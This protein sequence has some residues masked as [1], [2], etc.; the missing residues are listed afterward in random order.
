MYRA[1]I[2]SLYLD[3]DKPTQMKT[4]ID[5]AYGD[6]GPPMKIWILEFCRTSLNNNER[7]ER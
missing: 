2:K 5:A 6:H 7:V 3:D 1:V 4:E